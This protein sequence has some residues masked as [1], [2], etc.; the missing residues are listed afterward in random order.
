MRSR[1]SLTGH[2]SCPA[3]GKPAA[4][5]ATEYPAAVASARSWFSLM[6]KMC[7]RRRMSPRSCFHGPVPVLDQEVTHPTRGGQ[8]DLVEHE[9]ASRAQDAA[10][11][12]A[13]S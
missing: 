13:G 5:R 6:K 10:R 4:M 11:I 8:I 9:D 3:G 7:P 1:P 2:S 12:E